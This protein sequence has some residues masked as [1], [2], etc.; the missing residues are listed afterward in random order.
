MALTAEKSWLRDFDLDLDLLMGVEAPAHVQ[1]TC[2]R[3]WIGDQFNKSQGGW[4]VEV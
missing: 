2:S 4:C 3:V 1:A